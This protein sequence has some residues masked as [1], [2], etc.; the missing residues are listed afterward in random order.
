[1]QTPDTSTVARNLGASCHAPAL[2]LKPCADSQPG[3]N[4]LCQTALEKLGYF[5]SWTGSPGWLP[6]LVP[7]RAS[8]GGQEPAGPVRGQEHLGGARGSSWCQ[9]KRCGETRKLDL[10]EML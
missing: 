4:S 10:W 3:K 1:M 6:Q 9:A 8:T 7:G 5:I 2:A